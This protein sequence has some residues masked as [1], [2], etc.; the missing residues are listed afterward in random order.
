M[1]SSTAFNRPTAI[2]DAMIITKAVLSEWGPEWEGKRR[3]SNVYYSNMERFNDNTFYG[4]F[5]K[6]G[7]FK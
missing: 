7:I 3:S 2:A 1:G 6:Q 4:H 5:T